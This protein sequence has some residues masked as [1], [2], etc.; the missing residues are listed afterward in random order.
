MDNTDPDWGDFHTYIA[1]QTRIVCATSV[2]L[3]STAFPE[4]YRQQPL[5][6][7]DRSIAG[8]YRRTLIQILSATF[9]SLYAANC[10]GFYAILND[11]LHHTVHVSGWVC[12]SW[13]L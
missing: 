2:A 8:F 9:S 10:N 6:H 12:D 1:L 13:R 11:R 3:Q 4:A 7:C 5:P